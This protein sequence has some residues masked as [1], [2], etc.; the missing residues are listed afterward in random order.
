MKNMSVN[1]SYS[2]AALRYATPGAFRSL[3]GGLGR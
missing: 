2:N 3:I 1:P